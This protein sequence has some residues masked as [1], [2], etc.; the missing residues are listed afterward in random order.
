MIKFMIS[1][2]IGDEADPD[3]KLHRIDS[4]PYDWGLNKF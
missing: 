4:S 1:L 3:A 2:L